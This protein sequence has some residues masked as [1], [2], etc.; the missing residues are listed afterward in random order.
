V[1]AS[2]FRSVKPV[3][4]A[5]IA[6]TCAAPAAHAQ[7]PSRGAPVV[8]AASPESLAVEV[9]RRF[10]SGTPEAFDSIMIDPARAVVRDAAQRRR[11]RQGGLARVLWRERGRAVL[12]LSGTIA[13]PNP[14]D[15]LNIA[16]RFA[17]LYEAVESGGQWTIAR[18]LPFD[19]RNRILTQAVEATLTPGKHIE[20]A[21][22]LTI[23]VGAPYGF[24]ARLNPAVQL[25]EVTLDGRPAE[26]AL[27]GGVLWVRAPVRAKSRLVLRYGLELARSAHSAESDSIGP[28]YGGVQNDYAWLPFFDYDAAGDHAMVR[29][30]VHAP[31]AYQITTTLPQVESVRNGIRT[32]RGESREG[33]FVNSIIYDREWKRASGTVGGMT[34][35]TFLTPSFSVP[36]DTIESILRRTHRVLTARYGEP[37]NKYIAF[38]EQRSLTGGFRY[39]ANSNVMAGK[40]GG[41]VDVVGASPRA[42]L[43]HEIAHGWTNPAGA[44]ANFLREGWATLAEGDVIRDMYGPEVEHAF[45]E[46]RRNGYMAGSEGRLGILANPDN[47][48]VHYSKGS[49]ILRMLRDRM[50]QPAFERG[51][52]GYMREAATGSAGYREF[53]AHMSRAMG[54]DISSWIMPWLAET[55]AP[56]LDA[57]VEGTRVIVTQSGPLFDL[58]LELELTTSGGLVRRTLRVTRRADTLD[59]TGMGTVSAV[60]I[61]PDGKLLIK[62][63]LGEIARFEV[64]ADSA[65]QVA[66]TGDF[67]A[68]PIPATKQGDLWVAEIPMVQGRYSYAW[69]IDGKIADESD[70]TKSGVRIVRPAQ[71]VE[72]A[73]PKF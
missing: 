45:W 62:R 63:H 55:V 71:R 49:W 70:G 73:Y 50:G 72:N 46:V 2:R 13:L 6:V 23:A 9:M 14:G 4:V 17:G 16:R 37:V 67:S 34:W 18:Q 44:G 56:D 24:A 54:R 30:T 42:S 15:A 20:L 35:E 66:L 5:A 39:R 22:T 36:V 3:L 31:A 58:P 65:K 29:I 38:T 64:R 48:A 7:Q 43:A 47:G 51:M 60:R 25:K 26:H 27:G 21:D 57:R 33:T 1:I 40:G 19:D 32:V 12:L 61:D 69:Q 11:Q 53:I 59:I 8:G 10:E 52:R 41:P 28:I 68:R